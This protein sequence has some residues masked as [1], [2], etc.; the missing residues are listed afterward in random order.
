MSP[1][2]Q[3]MQNDDSQNPAMLWVQDGQAL[4]NQNQNSTPHPGANSCASCHGEAAHSMRAVSTRYPAL[5]VRLQRVINL[6]QRINACRQTHQQQAAWALESK[7][8]LSLESFLA[9]Q[10]RG[11]PVAA[12]LATSPRITSRSLAAGPAAQAPNAITTANHAAAQ[13]TNPSAQ[14]PDATAQK[15]WAASLVLGQQL[16]HQRMGQINLSCA[17]CHDE[18][19][20]QRL[21]ASVI[22]QA[23]PTG[24]PL[25]RLEWQSVGSLQRRIRNCMSGVRAQPFDFGSAE[26]VALE[27][28]LAQRAAGMTSQAPAVR[29]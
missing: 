6:A 8:L 14:V 27:L 5:D 26:L 17:Q 19:A 25:Y 18:R 28:A 29:P 12:V 9:L 22:P 15:R 10:S 21:G 23:H 4:W 1:A 2:L 20:S 7:E 3:A 24:Y 16:W 11:L 13:A